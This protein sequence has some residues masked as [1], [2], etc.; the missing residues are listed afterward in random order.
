LYLDGAEETS[1]V[2]GNFTPRADSI[3]HAAIGSALGS[4]GVVGSG[5][6]GFF[7]GVIDEVRIWNIARTGT[8]IAN[9]MAW[10]SPRPRT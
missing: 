9:G 5:T 2:V 4:K 3:Q 10:R 7:N 8:D 1:L 6:Q